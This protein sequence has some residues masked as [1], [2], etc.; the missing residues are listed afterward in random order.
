MLKA[1]TSRG[2]DMPPAYLVHCNRNGALQPFR[3]E[4]DALAMTPNVSILHVFSKPSKEDESARNFDVSGRLTF[5]VIED[6]IGDAHIMDGDL[7]IDMPLFEF[8][9]YVCGPESFQADMINGLISA[10]A[11]QHQIFQESFQSGESDQQLGTIAGAEVVFSKPDVTVTWDA[12]ENVTL[13]ELAEA[14]GLSPDNA[15]RMGVC[16][17]CSQELLEGEVYYEMRPTHYPEDNQVL[18]C[19]ARPASRRVVLSG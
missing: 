12:G 17:S 4:L 9:F 11:N 18:L 5:D 1:H 13:L 14:A 8:D 7:R 16:Q 15:C 2:E 10:G 19:C 6:F 3:E